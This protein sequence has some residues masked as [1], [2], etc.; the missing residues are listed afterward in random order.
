MGTHWSGLLGQGVVPRVLRELYVQLRT[1]L[2]RLDNNSNGRGAVCLIQGQ[3]GWGQSS[4]PECQLGPVLVRCELLSQEALDQVSELVGGENRLGDLLLQFGSL[5]SET[6]EEGLALQV[7]E[8]LLVACSWQDGTWFFEECPV[9][10][11]RGYDRALRVAPGNLILDAAWRLGDSDFVRR[12]LGDLDRPLQ[13]TTDPLLR[14]QPITLTHWDGVLLSHVD[15]MRPARQVLAAASADTAVSERSLFGLVS[16]G[17]VEF[18]DTASRGP[19][20]VEAPLTRQEVVR[21]SEGLALRDHFEV[22][23]LP[24]TASEEDARS[25]CV[26]LARRFHPSA[27]DG[28][29]LVGLRPQLE[30]IFARLCEASRVLTDPKRRADYETRLR[31]L[32]ITPSRTEQP[33]VQPPPDPVAAHALNERALAQ[34]ELDLAEGRYWDALQAA[35][36]LLSELKGRLRLRALLLRAR[37][38]AKNPMWQREALDQLKELARED[39]TNLDALLLL[40]Q[41]YN[42]QGLTVVA[43]GTFR[44]VLGL[45]PRHAEALAALAS[46]DD[47]LQ[48]RVETRQPLVAG[49]ALHVDGAHS[50]GTVWRGPM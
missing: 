47:E 1:G 7:R 40:G 3:I 24:R 33:A 21:A 42:A 41:L 38:Y 29:P 50:R 13:L 36:G 22:L 46:C 48:P 44:K 34:A 15:G 10:R 30:E 25:A 19:A 12:E 32:E 9:E 37:A 31:L 17:L 8:T 45:R 14:F 11:F 16:V 23:D 6:L 43:A 26:R 4:L 49:A 35:E 18:V 27:A 5:D 2:L 20:E 28:P 39:P